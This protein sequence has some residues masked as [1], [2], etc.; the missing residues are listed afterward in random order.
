MNCVSWYEAFAFCVWDGGRLPTEAEWEYAAA[1]G[2]EARPYPWG[3]ASEPDGDRALFAC[4]ACGA[5]D[6]DPVGARPQGE[7]RYDQFDL[8]GS[9]SEWTLDYFAPYGKRCDNCANVSYGTERVARG[10]HLSSDEEEIQP[11]ARRSF[12]PEARHFTRGFRCAR[13]D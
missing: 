6:L 1:G 9:V 7:G 12:V 13:P 10:G 11:S 5:D 8:A 3:A 4:M 2:D